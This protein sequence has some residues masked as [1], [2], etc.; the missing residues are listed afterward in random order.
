MGLSTGAVGAAGAASLLASGLLG[1]LAANP[2]MAAGPAGPAGRGGAAGAGGAAVASLL[3]G[4]RAVVLDLLWLRAEARRAEGRTLEL[5]AL[6]RTIAAL[7][8]RIERVW[9]FHADI[10]A[11]N[12]PLAAAGSPDQG[13]PFVVE[14]LRL[15]EEG[16]LWNPRS[17]RLRRALAQHLLAACRT[18]RGPLLPARIAEAFG[19]EPLAWAEALL[20]EAASDPDHEPLTDAWRAVA[21]R[22]IVERGGEEAARARDA[23]E[24]L[25]GHIREAHPRTYDALFSEQPAEDRGR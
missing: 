20:R 24:S 15:L 10:L 23:L 16:L 3:G 22:R 9:E 17:E 13:A 2:A 18:V 6:L 21:L 25:I 11:L 7:S 4:A 1:G 12:L 8:P 19:R 5:P 14:G